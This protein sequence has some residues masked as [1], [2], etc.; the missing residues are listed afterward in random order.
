M[1]AAEASDTWTNS[2]GK[3]IEATY[4][5]IA[6][7]SLI[8][9]KDSKVH[10]VALKDLNQDSQDKAWKYQIIKKLSSVKEWTFFRKTISF[11]I[12]GNAKDTRS[13][14]DRWKMIG[15]AKGKFVMQRKR[16]Q[17]N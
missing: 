2:K 7:D 13:T 12:R 5:A 3:T 10:V 4:V 1:S 11:D 14:E 6:D 8:I 16:D 9:Q 17:E 15:A